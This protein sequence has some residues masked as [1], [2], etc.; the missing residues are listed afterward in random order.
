VTTLELIAL[1]E[2][3]R[4]PKY[5]IAVPD[6]LR[7]P[8]PVVARLREAFAA[9]LTPDRYNLVRPYC[10]GE[11]I[12]LGVGAKSGPRVLRLLNTLFL[13]LKRRGW[14]VAARP[15]TP[16]RTR[17]NDRVRC[18]M[19]GEEFGFVLREKLTMIHVPPDPKDRF[20]SRSVRYEPKGILE[21]GVT[22]GYFCAPGSFRG[23]KKLKLEDQLNDVIVG[24]LVAVERSRERREARRREEQQRQLAEQA[25]RERERLEQL[26]RE[27]AAKF[28][29]MT[30]RWVTAAHLRAF[31]DAVKT[32]AA[33]REVTADADP[34]FARWLEW[35]E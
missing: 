31:L 21:L 26:E 27:R 16:G 9:G 25:R 10:D 20:S 19:L 28:E 7:S 22:G 4:D 11:S 34:G 35:A 1:V 13:A 8:H 15:R 30:E 23:G 17:E 33:R 5:R 29:S 24:L 2:R 12:D 32:E 3:E 6:S 14:P 18:S